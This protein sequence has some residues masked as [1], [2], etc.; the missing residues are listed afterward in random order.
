MFLAEDIHCKL[1]E[2]LEKMC[3]EKNSKDA[4]SACLADSVD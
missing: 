3:Y 2:I 4:S 1:G